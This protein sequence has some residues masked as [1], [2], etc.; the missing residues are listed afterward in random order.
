MAERPNRKPNRT[1]REPRLAGATGASD[2]T[3][4]GGAA[5]GIPDA[6]LQ[7]RTGGTASKG[8]VQRDREKLFPET[9]GKPPSPPPRGKSRRGR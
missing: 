4:G 5:A 1:R 8:Q 3:S 6:D 7:M 2:A 9:K